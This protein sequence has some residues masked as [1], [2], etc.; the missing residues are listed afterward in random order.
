MVYSGHGYCLDFRFDNHWLGCPC[1]AGAEMKISKVLQWFGFDRD[2]L[3]LA[4]LIVIAIILFRIIC[5]NPLIDKINNLPAIDVN[6]SVDARVSGDINADVSGNIGADV[7][8]SMR[9]DV[10]GSVGIDGNITA[11]SPLGGFDVKVRD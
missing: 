5:I 10:S 7:S 9:T 1:N 4:I 6:G 3:K 11:D 2:D 8:G